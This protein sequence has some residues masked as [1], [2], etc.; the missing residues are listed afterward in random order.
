MWGI[1]IEG[2][3]TTMKIA[4]HRLNNIAYLQFIGKVMGPIPG[5]NCVITK[6]IVKCASVGLKNT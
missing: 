2:D 6:D 3:N 4:V 5:R 1:G